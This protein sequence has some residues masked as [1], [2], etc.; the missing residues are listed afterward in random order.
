MKITVLL[1]VYNGDPTLTSAIESILDQ[2]LTDFDFLII[3]DASTD[4]SAEIIRDYAER[5]TRIRPLFNSENIGLAKTLNKGIETA[6]GEFIVRMDQDDESLPHRL[7]TQYLY[8]KN[9]PAVMVAGSYVFHMGK[10]RNKDRLVKLPT[11]ASEIAKTLKI[12]NCLYHPSVIFRREPIIG[13]GGYRAEFK[14]AEDYDL[15]LR[16]SRRCKIAN[17]PVALL[18]YRFSIDGMTLGRK[19][20]QLYYIFLA[21]TYHENPDKNW[22]Q[23]ELLAKKMHA[24]QSKEKFLGD[25]VDGTVNELVKLGFLNLALRLLCRMSANVGWKR[26]FEIVRR[27]LWSFGKINAAPQEH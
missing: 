26:T 23:I 12:E 22:Q 21:Q 14:N 11:T 4:R 16:V 19:W 17:I 9:R 25:V 20:E 7:R 15:W 13:L 10:E 1:P 24:Q 8:M 27:Q 3:D 5:D 18:R 6:K 2:D